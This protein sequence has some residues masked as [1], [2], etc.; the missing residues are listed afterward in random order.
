MDQVMYNDLLENTIDISFSFHW[1]GDWYNPG[2]RQDTRKRKKEI[3]VHPMSA[4]RWPLGLGLRPV[5]KGR[6]RLLSRQPAWWSIV[7]HSQRCSC[8][9]AS[10]SSRGWARLKT[11]GLC[12]WAS[13]CSVLP[14]ATSPSAWHRSR[15]GCRQCATRKGSRDRAVGR[16]CIPGARCG[17]SPM[18]S[19]RAGT[20]AGAAGHGERGDQQSNNCQGWPASGRSI[21]MAVPS[22][23]K[24][25]SRHCS[26]WSHGRSRGKPSE[27]S[28]F[29]SRSIS[30]G[31]GLAW[32]WAWCAL[33][34][35]RASGI[36]RSRAHQWCHVCS[37]PS[38]FLAAHLPLFWLCNI[39][40]GCNC[41]EAV[42][43]PR[44]SARWSRGPP[45][46]GNA[47]H[48]LQTWWWTR[49]KKHVPRSRIA[50]RGHSRLDQHQ[51]SWTKACASPVRSRSWTP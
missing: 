14:C 47:G 36:G 43:S 17:S 51:C 32:R 27:Q 23:S 46:T 20:M 28:R 8:S 19:H 40:Q 1:K 7:G 16:M 25:A 38:D 10:K 11:Q 21:L 44:W 22:I 39:A 15:V 6:P 31:A 29:R 26:W 34:P 41:I 18:L 9:D 13:A 42:R 2:R 24:W 30:S 49:R 48:S 33:S 45:R 35:A 3:S 5:P 50:G 12:A 4:V 37:R